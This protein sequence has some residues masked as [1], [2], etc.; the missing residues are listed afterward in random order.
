M[1]A[2]LDIDWA[3]VGLGTK[4]DAEVA[5]DLKLPVSTVL[6]ARRRLGIPAYGHD[7]VV[8]DTSHKNIDWDNEPLGRMPDR[9][10]A[11]RHKVSPSTVSMARSRRGIPGYSA[12]SHEERCIELAKDVQTWLKNGDKSVDCFAEIEELLTRHKLLPEGWAD[13]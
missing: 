13:Q 11:R 1:V 6:N 5:F 7:G 3:T 4:T 9:M 8:R 10:L 2:K 12:R